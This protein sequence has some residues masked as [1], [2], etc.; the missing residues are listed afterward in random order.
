[1]GTTADARRDLRIRYVEA[2]EN[3]AASSSVVAMDAYRA[4]LTEGTDD[5]GS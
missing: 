4:A 5:G 3:K 2:T 1:M